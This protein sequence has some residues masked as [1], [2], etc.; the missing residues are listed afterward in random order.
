MRAV[1]PRRQPRPAISQRHR[2]RRRLL[3]ERIVRARQ[4]RADARQVL[5]VAIARRLCEEAAEV[6]ERFSAPPR[7]G[8]AACRG[9]TACRSHAGRARR[10][11]A[12]PSA[13]APRR[14]AAS[15]APRPRQP[16]ACRGSSSTTRR[17]AA[18]AA[19][20]RRAP[21]SSSPRLYQVPAAVG[22]ASSSRSNARRASSDLAQPQQDDAELVERLRIAAAAATADC[23]HV[24]CFRAARPR[25]PAPAPFS[26]ATPAAA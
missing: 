1:P 9:C 14:R 8:R 4:Q 13:A 7:F 11:A 21:I 23:Q 24:A 10:P 19:A 6:R 12:T 25:R 16:S 20:G 5:R 15:A 2:R 18:A 3:H 22:S 17:N 26:S